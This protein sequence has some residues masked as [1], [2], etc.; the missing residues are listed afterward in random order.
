MKQVTVRDY[1][2]TKDEPTF[3]LRDAEEI[4]SIDR[5]GAWWHL[6]TIEE[7]TCCSEC[8]NPDCDGKTYS[9]DDLM[10]PVVDVLED[11]CNRRGR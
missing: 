10:G 6:I 4:F 3:E 1:V 2:E 8:G 5:T 11:L 9:L 7:S